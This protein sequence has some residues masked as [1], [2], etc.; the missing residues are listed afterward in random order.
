MQQGKAGAKGDA[1]HALMSAAGQL[2]QSKRLPPGVRSPRLTT[3]TVTLSA[4]PRRGAPAMPR[5]L[6]YGPNYYG[7]L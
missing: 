4:P 2:R 5:P 3:A 1:V 6:K 7:I